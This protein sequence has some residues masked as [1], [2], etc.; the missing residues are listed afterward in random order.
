MWGNELLHKGLLSQCFSGDRL[1]PTLASTADKGQ[2][3]K[4]INDE[5]FLGEIQTLRIN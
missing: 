3:W 4:H 1:E 2:E 5:I